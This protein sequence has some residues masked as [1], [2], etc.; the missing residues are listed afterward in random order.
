MPIPDTK[1]A[2]A[3]RSIG[4]ISADEFASE[5][6]ISSNT[7]RGWASRRSTLMKTIHTISHGMFKFY[8]RGDLEAAAKGISERR[9]AVAPL[10]KKVPGPQ[11]VSPT[12]KQ[13]IC[14]EIRNEVGELAG[15]LEALDCKVEA[16]CRMLKATLVA[17]GMDTGKL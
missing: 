7:I 1:V 6:G 17:L 16:V 11:D 9:A 5:T 10:L 15:T 12:L 4:Y 3:M 13:E 14:E 8:L 2:D